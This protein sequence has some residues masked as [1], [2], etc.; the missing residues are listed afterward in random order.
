[1]NDLVT[2]DDIVR[3]R[4]DPAFRQA[5]MARNLERLLGMLNTLRKNYVKDPESKRQIREGVDLAVKLADKL[6]KNGRNTGITAA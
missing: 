6:Q 4:T 2:D 1:M 5:L 3:A